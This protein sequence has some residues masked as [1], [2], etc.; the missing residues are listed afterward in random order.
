MDVLTLEINPILNNRRFP[1]LT[2]HLT[3]DDAH[4]LLEP[5][6]LELKSQ[7][8]RQIIRLEDELNKER[9]KALELSDALASH[10]R[11]RWWQ[12]RLALM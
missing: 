9:K 1:P 7:Y 3:G 2:V 4:Q 11:K 8:L 5:I 6:Q 10:T 12:K